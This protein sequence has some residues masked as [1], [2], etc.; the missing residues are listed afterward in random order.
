MLAEIEQL[1]AKTQ[2][3]GFVEFCETRFMICY[4]CGKSLTRNQELVKNLMISKPEYFE[5]MDSDTKL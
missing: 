1:L 2:T 4:L 5:K 3:A